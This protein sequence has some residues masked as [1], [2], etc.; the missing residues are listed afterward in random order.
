M[1]EGAFGALLRVDLRRGVGP[2]LRGVALTLAALF[3][4]TL[5]GHGDRENVGIVLFGLTSYYL[6]WPPTTAVQD[7][8][9]GGLEF[10]SGLPVDSRVLARARLTAIAVLLLPIPLQLTLTWWVWVAPALGVAPDLP[11]TAA[12]FLLTWGCAVG[13]SGVAAGV[14][15]RWGMDALGRWPSIA[16]ALVWIFVIFGGQRFEPAV[17]AVLGAVVERTGLA[18]GAGGAAALVVVLALTGSYRLLSKGF[19]EFQPDPARVIG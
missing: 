15:I 7:R 2:I 14:L 6:L 16:L 9:G 11:R 19:E 3:V 1:A 8:L 17:G 5:L 12:V 18:V 4:V 10:L 13:V